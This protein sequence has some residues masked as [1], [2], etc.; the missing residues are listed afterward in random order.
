MIRRY[1]AA[2]LAST[3]VVVA[4]VTLLIVGLLHGVYL[5]VIGF[6]LFGLIRDGVNS[7]RRAGR[8]ELALLDGEDDAELAIVEVVIRDQGLLV[9]VDRG[10]IWTGDNLFHFRGTAC[11]FALDGADYELR[12]H[13]LSAVLA[14][15]DAPWITVTFN[16]LRLPRS[17]RE[18]SFGQV[19]TRASNLVFR[20]ETSNE[21]RRFPPLSRPPKA[22]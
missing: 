7:M 10:V 21:F 20:E 11:Y 8:A 3:L 14:L 4:L 16:R 13:R 15:E 22:L 19:L 18:T 1:Q 2:G 12:W 6:G 17:I 5:F 9:G